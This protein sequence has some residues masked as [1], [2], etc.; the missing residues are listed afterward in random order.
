MKREE[1][2]ERRVLGPDPE[3]PKA[4]GLIRGS[5][6][7][8]AICSLWKVPLD[9]M[10]VDKEWLEWEPEVR[11]KDSVN[12]VRRKGRGTEMA[13]KALG[14]WMQG[15]GRRGVKD[16]S[17]PLLEQPG[18]RNVRRKRTAGEEGTK[19]RL[20][21][22]GMEQNVGWAALNPREGSVSGEKSSSPHGDECGK[23]EE[24]KEL[25]AEGCWVCPL[26]SPVPV[27]T[28]V[29]REFIVPCETEC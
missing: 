24:R 5:G 7:V 28:P 21:S 19:N 16:D 8:I 13:L 26:T 23:W 12:Q 27:P 15:S 25:L 22:W 11:D 3:L 20:H 18:P 17:K 2:E 14:N 9:D 29:T 10:E 1:G 6:E 4:C